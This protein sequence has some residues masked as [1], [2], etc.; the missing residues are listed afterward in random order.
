M[1]RNY[2]SVAFRSLLKRKVFSIVNILGLAI[3]MSATFMILQYVQYEWSYDKFH[4][5]GDRIYRVLTNRGILSGD[6]LFA[7]THPGVAEALE[8]DFPEVEIAVRMVPQSVFLNDGSAWSYVN[9]RGEYTTFHETEVYNVDPDFLKLFSFRMLR[10]D[11]ATALSDPSSVVISSSIALKYF[12]SDDPLGKSLLL[13]NERRFT[14]TAV[15]EDVPGNSHMSFDILVSYFFA[16]GQWNHSVDWVWPEFPT[17][18][19]LARGA[20]PGN[21]E[22]LFDPF[23]VKYMGSRM[24]EMGF[25]EHLKLQPLY[26]IHLRS[27]EMAKERNPHGRATTVYLLLVLAMLILV[28]AWINYINLSTSKATERAGEVGIR[29]VVGAQRRELIVQFLAESAVTNGIALAVSFMLTFVAYSYFV[30]LSG[31]EMGDSI[32]QA[33]LISEP[34]FWWTLPVIFLLGSFLAGLY[35]A[36]VLS[37]MKISSVLKGKFS[38]S[39]MGLVMRRSLVAFQFFISSLL[40]VGTIAVFSQVD[41]MQDQELGYVKEQ[42]LVIRRPHIIVADSS[43]TLRA[44]SFKTEL[45]RDPAVRNVTMSSEI[46]G[47]FITKVSSIRMPERGPEYIM[48]AFTY[49]IDSDFLDTYGMNLIAGRNFK[50]GEKFQNPFDRGNPVLLTERAV[51]AIGFDQVED[52]VGQEIA[53][54]SNNDFLAEVVGIVGDFHQHSLGEGYKPILF[55]PASGPISEYFTVRMEMYDHEG[56]IRHLK[57]EFDRAFPGNEF[58]YFFL[59]EFFNQQY[60]EDQQFEKVFGLFASLSLIVTCLGLIGLSTFAISQRTREILIRRVFGATPSSIIYLFSRDFLNL[61]ILANA[62]A[63]PVSIFL[64][65][66]WLENFAFRVPLSWMIFAVPAVV[67]AFMSVAT[68][69]VQAVKT[70]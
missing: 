46:P 26:D 35:P 48:S 6:A 37:S 57:N 19:K 16:E 64:V 59:D 69:S 22:K 65:N 50:I 44:E 7:T 33:G 15:I 31:K 5:D 51:R 42:L 47:K 54:G 3:G 41:Y 68:L 30:R 43:I 63:L 9:E 18:I 38:G 40:I 60:A 11:P 27:P 20:D 55:M 2:L 70:S 4:V 1:I 25:V 34:W 29:K 58:N 13:N 21:L 14:V 56:T 52:I 24:K 36:F 39:R 53:F 67:L 17:Y 10:G 28:I 8:R 62:V 66:R 32:F 45:K 12:G 49:K 61:V 23:L